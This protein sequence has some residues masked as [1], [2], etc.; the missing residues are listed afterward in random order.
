MKDVA[1]KVCMYVNAMRKIFQEN[2]NKVF[3]IQIHKMKKKR[4]Y[5]RDLLQPRRN[6]KETDLRTLNLILFTAPKLKVRNT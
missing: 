6:R 1:A 3:K 4:K 2:K 5:I